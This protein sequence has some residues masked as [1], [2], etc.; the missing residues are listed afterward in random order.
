[1]IVSRVYPA[2][3]ALNPPGFA[4]GGEL[5]LAAAVDQRG[6]G[7]R[8]LRLLH[9]GGVDQHAVDSDRAAALGL[10]LPVGGDIGFGA[11]DL[12]GGRRVDPVGDRNLVGVDGPFAGVAQQ[13]GASRSYPGRSR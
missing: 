3:N 11:G 9:V 7:Q 12:V 4:D 10:G 2:A 8:L 13:G 1:L 5:P 6:P